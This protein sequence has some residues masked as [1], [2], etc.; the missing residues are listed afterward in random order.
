MTRRGY[1]TCQ[2]AGWSTWAVMNLAYFRSGALELSVSNTAA[3]PAAETGAGVGLA[4][5]HERLQLRFRAKMTV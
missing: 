5:A 4:N 2:I 1:A 3:G